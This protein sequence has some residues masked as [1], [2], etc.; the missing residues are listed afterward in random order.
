[1]ICS[2]KL[3]DD[4]CHGFV[5]PPKGILSL[6]KGKSNTVF[7]FPDPILDRMRLSGDFLKI[8]LQGS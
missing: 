3:D 1:M 8:L 2:V 4:K 6:R 5:G 7:I